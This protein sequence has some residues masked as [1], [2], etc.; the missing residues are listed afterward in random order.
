MIRAT[1]LLLLAGLPVAAQQIP[2]QQ[3]PQAARAETAIAPL[4][5]LR[6][7]DKIS[8]E[9]E[10]FNVPAQGIA[11]FKRIAIEVDQCRYPVDNPSG[12]AF[13]WV[14]ISDPF[15]DQPV[16]FEGWMIASAPALNAMD[17]PRYDVWLIRCSGSEPESSAEVDLPDD[18]VRSDGTVTSSPRERPWR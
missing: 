13:A 3:V 17:H 15:D 6:G 16:R 12:D 1:I 9:V 2:L 5:V 11:A 10:E 7:V 14:R 18:F 8:G 4:A